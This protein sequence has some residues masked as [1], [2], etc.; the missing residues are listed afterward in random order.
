MQ[1]PYPPQLLIG[2]STGSESPEAFDRSGREFLQYFKDLTDVKPH[3]AILDVGCGTGRMARAL[4]TYL[5]ERG[6]YRGFDISR[7]EIEWCTKNISSH[8]PNFAFEWSDVANTT[9]NP[10]GAYSPEAF[11]FPYSDNT[12]DLV[13]LTSVF[14]HMLP[15]GFK[16]YLAEVHRVLRRGGECF[17]T[18]FLLNDDQESSIR[19]NP[20]GAAF[21]IPFRTAGDPYAVQFPGQP[22]HVVGY[23]EPYIRDSYRTCGLQICEPIHYGHW[24]GRKEF[25]SGQDI[26]IARKL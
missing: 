9:Y 5:N 8:L 7:A 11:K 4:T 15:P 18:Y 24:T 26:V 13:F 19:K 12:F 14:T 20:G 17:I 22:E 10:N 25:L 6:I 21:T 2:T 1:I 16:N 23:D 3:S